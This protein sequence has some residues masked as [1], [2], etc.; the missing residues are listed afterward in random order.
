[1]DDAAGAGSGAPVR[2]KSGR[3]RRRPLTFDASD[4]VKKVKTEQL[5]SKEKAASAKAKLEAAMKAA[6]PSPADPTAFSNA[7]QKPKG[8]LAV[9]SRHL[10]WLAWPLLRFFPVAFFIHF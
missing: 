10:R 3:D 5:S 2:R 9:R 1:M 8:R 7:A 4:P 6:L